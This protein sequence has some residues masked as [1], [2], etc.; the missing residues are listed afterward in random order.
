[1][2]VLRGIIC[3]I[4]FFTRIISVSYPRT[5]DIV[6]GCGWQDGQSL[7]GHNIMTFY[8]KKDYRLDAAR[9]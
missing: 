2:D 1:M 8:K 4:L 6:A 9:K 5:E 3:L 7:L